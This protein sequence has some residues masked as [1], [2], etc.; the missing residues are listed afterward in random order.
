MIYVKRVLPAFSSKNRTVSDL[1]CGSFIHVESTF[2]CGVK[3]CSD[4]IVLHVTVHFPQ[5]HLIEETVFSPLY[6]LASFVID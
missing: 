1:A 3:E 4:F 5:H 2:V 6:V